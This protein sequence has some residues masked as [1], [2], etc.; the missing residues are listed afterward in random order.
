MYYSLLLFLAAIGAGLA[1]LFVLCTGAAYF[2]G[3]GLVKLLVVFAVIIIIVFALIII[4]LAIKALLY[5]KRC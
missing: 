3:P 1:L 4:F 2:L 5:R